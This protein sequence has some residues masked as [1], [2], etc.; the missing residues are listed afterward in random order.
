MSKIEFLINMAI[1][2]IS[3]LVPDK[4]EYWNPAFTRSGQNVLRGIAKELSKY[5]DTTIVSCLPTA[6]FPHAPLWIPGKKDILE[7]GQEI[8]IWP[9]LNIQIIKIIFWGLYSLYFMGNWA[10]KHKEGKRKVLAY[11]IYTPPIEWL[12]QACKYTKSQLYMILMDLG[13]PPARLGLSKVRMLGYKFSEKKAHKYIPKIDGRIVINEKMVNEYAP[14][15]DYILVDGG[16]NDEVISR[17]FPLKESTEKTVIYVLAG[18]LWDQN[19]TKLVLDAVKAHPELDVKVIFAGK[20]N[21]VRLIENAAKTDDRIQYAG[22]LNMDKLFKIYE[23]A[24]VL[25]N[26]R[27]EEA[28]DMHFPSKLLECLAMGKLVL[29]TPVAH[30]ER[31]YGQY[32][33]ILH[34]I[35]PEGLANIMMQI[36]SL[37]KSKLREIGENARAFMLANRTWAVRTKEIVEYMNSK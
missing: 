13:V 6:S 15:K 36:A 7:D 33:R 23:N 21:D 1:L 32:M 8:C 18:M 10:K 27:I 12:Y 11:N 29:S 5:D 22:M 25:L 9:T 2:F 26:L 28:D 31:D 30:A 34:D 37:P 20:G 14:N 24:D 35:T 17:L 3:N 16:V 4:E 19:G